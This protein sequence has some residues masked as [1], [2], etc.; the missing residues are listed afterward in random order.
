MSRSTAFALSVSL[1]FLSKFNGAVFFIL[2]PFIAA[3]LFESESSVVALIPIYLIGCSVSQFFVGS[4]ADA[5]GKRTVL[6]CL[7]AAFAGGAIGCALSASLIQT[8]WS[9]FLMAMGTGA[10]SGIGNTLLFDG[11]RNVGKAAKSLSLSSLFVIWAPAIAMNLGVWI[12]K[13]DWRVLF[14]IQALAGLALIFSVLKTVPAEKNRTSGFQLRTTL[15]GYFD[16]LKSPTYR[17]IATQMCL[18]GGGIALFYTVGLAYLQTELSADSLWLGW[19]PVWVVISN[20]LGRLISS[21]LSPDFLFR[22]ATRV[23][24]LCCVLG[25]A[26]ICLVTLFTENSLLRLSPMGIYVVGV[27]IMFSAQRAQLM[28]ESS[29]RTATSESLLGILMSL[30]GAVITSIGAWTL[31]TLIVAPIALGSLLLVFG[32]Y[33][34]LTSRKNGTLCVR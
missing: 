11:C 23:G 4:F 5:W 14:W 27:G 32:G 19:V 1:R 34:V 22:H 17:R 9:V 10:I 25:A 20:S 30:S 2:I 13:L 8:G 3:G 21:C 16:L 29:G 24:S 31:T 26:G 28:K 18:T 6:I 15:N 12:A 7:L 33:T